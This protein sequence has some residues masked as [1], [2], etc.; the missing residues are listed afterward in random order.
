MAIE[1][2][3]A[4]APTDR[5]ACHL[6]WLASEL[7][8]SPLKAIIV[9]TGTQAY[10]RPDGIAVVPLSL[11]G[12]PGESSSPQRS[13]LGPPC[14]DNLPEKESTGAFRRRCLPYWD[15]PIMPSRSLHYSRALASVRARDR[16]FLILL[17]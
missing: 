16:S 15:H 14:E 6:N 9:T 11:L 4:A 1:T 7:G 8:D 3:L 5:D 13:S 17:R 12:R 2:K 10:R